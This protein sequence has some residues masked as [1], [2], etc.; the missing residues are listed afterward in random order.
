MARRKKTA[1]SIN[2]SAFVRSLPSSMPAADVVKAAKAK[3]ITLSDKYVH[4][5][6]YN[7]KTTG[8]KKPSPTAATTA[9]APVMTVTPTAPVA[10]RRGPGRPPKANAR[11]ARP[12][13]EASNGLVAELELLVERVVERKIGEVLRAKLRGI[14]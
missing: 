5:I 13:V 7:A 8:K 4:T 11:P 12:T 10:P 6:R 3:G 2:K 14:L 1:G 9:A